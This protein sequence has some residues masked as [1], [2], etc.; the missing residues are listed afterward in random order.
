MEHKNLS[1]EFDKGLIEK[2]LDDMDMRYVILFMYIIRNDLFKDLANPNLIENYERVLILD[3][4]FKSNILKFWDD[5][6]IETAI[7]L[8]LFKNI[9][10]IRDFEQKDSDFIIKLGEETITIENNIISVPDDN[11]FLMINKKVKS[12][13][14]RNFNLALT[15]LKGVRCENSSIIHPFIYEIAEHDYRLSNDLYYLLDQWGNIYQT[16][17][18]EVTIEGF[19]ERFTEIYKKIEEF[20]EIFESKLT[21]KPIKKKI[22]FAL[23]NN[24]DVFKYLAE[25]GISLSEKFKFE[26]IDKNKEIFKNWYFKLLLLINVNYKMKSIENSL[27]SLKKL[28]SGKTK[29]NTYLK[30]IEKISFNEDNI[31]DNIQKTLIDLRS[32]LIEINEQISD[33]SKR[34]LKLLNL[35]YEKYVITSSES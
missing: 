14:R 13:S 8:G 29:V 20:L 6:F 30:F 3:E 34:D 17:K 22:E 9:R 19:Y 28:Y 18:I 21:T 11:L 12:I 15:R 32:K 25:E 1:I 2:I 16:I 26:K 4:I 35:D 33:L 5:E 23:D 27:S 7:D 24:K 31:V 10:S